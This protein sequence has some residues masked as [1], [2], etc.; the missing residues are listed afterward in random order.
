M[1]TVSSTIQTGLPRANGTSDYSQLHTELPQ[2]GLGD[3]ANAVCVLYCA[4]T[5]E[6]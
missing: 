2:N 1:I 3:L 4:V 6:S 5:P